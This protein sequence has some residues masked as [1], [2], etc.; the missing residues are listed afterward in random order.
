M[1][2][3]AGY[4]QEERDEGRWWIEGDHWCRQWDEWAYGET[5]RFRVARAGN[6]IFWLDDDGRTIDE[7]VIAPSPT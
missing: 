2:G 5:G 6:R 4:A 1:Q 7:A 3:R